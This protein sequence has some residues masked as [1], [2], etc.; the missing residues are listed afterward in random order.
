M[1]I[2][3]T[4]TLSAPVQ[5][6]FDRKLL[7]VKTPY[8]I[9]G[10]AA[11]PKRM[12]AGGGTSLRQRRYD[13]L[14]TATVP[15]GNSGVTPAGQLLNAT[16]IDSTISFY[17]TYVKINEQ[18][19]LQSQ[20]P[21][22]NEA[23]TLLGI[24][25][26][27]TEDELIRESLKATATLVDAKNG[28]NGDGPTEIS[29]K[30]IAIV[31]NTL[32]D[33]DAYTLLDKIEGKDAIGTAPVR[34]A[35]FALCSTKLTRD[36]D[37]LTDFTSKWNYPSQQNLMQSEYGAKNNLRFL[38]SSKGSFDAGT[39]TLGKDVYNIFCVGLEAYTCIKQDKY[40]AKFIYRPAIYDGPL[41]QNVTLGYKLAQVSRVVNDSWVVR[42]RV[43]LSL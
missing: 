12:P 41:A 17:G 15:L 3:T 43:T 8:L 36:L 24:S 6:N 20:D 14:K 18:V 7:L 26:R 2:N 5:D 34:D 32:L 10:V 13:K 27:E 42:F 25:L 37:S 23:A 22:L 35:Y 38:V 21:V 19:T 39:S 31:T 30:D 11:V 33:N 29:S 4:A 9:H 1:A 28:T 16:D 40:S